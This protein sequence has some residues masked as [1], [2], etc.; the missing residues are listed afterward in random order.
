LTAFAAGSHSFAEAPALGRF[1]LGRDGSLFQM[2]S[3]PDGMRIVRFG[4]KEER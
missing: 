1:V 3:S 2:T 4:V